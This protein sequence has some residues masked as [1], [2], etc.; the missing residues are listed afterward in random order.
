MSAKVILVSACLLGVNTKYD[1]GNNLHAGVAQLHNEVVVVP[2]CPEQLGGLTTPREA[3]EINNGDG[4]DVLKGA[5]KV[6]TKAGQE[7]T[8]AFLKGA[9]ESLYLAQKLSAVGALLKARSP[10]CGSGCIY[11][12]DFSGKVKPGDGVTAA[13]L[14]REGLPVFTE[15]QLVEFKLWLAS[16]DN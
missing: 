13:L 8:V 2:F 5:A 16:G 14:K 9:Q 15:E 10:S 7:R 1:G 3:V 12:G 11:A 6:K 4:N